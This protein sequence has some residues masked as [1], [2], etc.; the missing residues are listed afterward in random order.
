[1]THNE[2]AIDPGEE[3]MP[4]VFPNQYSAQLYCNYSYLKW[5]IYYKVLL[6]LNLEKSKG[7]YSH[8]KTI[9]KIGFYTVRSGFT[10]LII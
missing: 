7:L 4:V 9:G 3:P 5:S 10:Y 8:Q 1:M 2:S 6:Q